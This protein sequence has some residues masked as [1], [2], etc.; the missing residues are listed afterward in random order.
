MPPSYW[1]SEDRK[2]QWTL[3]LAVLVITVV[4]TGLKGK[5]KKRR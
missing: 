4:T 1:L 5:P 3:S 2:L